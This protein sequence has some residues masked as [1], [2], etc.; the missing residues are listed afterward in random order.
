M[1]LLLLFLYTLVSQSHT[2]YFADICNDSSGHQCCAQTGM[3][4]GDPD[5]PNKYWFMENT[6]GTWEDMDLLCNM[7]KGRLVVIESRREN[8]CLVKYAMDEYK[9]DPVKYYA[10][11]LRTPENY[12]GVYEW[13]HVDNQPPN[14]DAA[15]PSFTNWKPNYFPTGKHCVT[16]SIGSTAPING[17]WTD[18]DCTNTQVHG[19]CEKVEDA[20]ASS[21]TKAAT[22]T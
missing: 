19:I 17:L 9:G 12:N 11:G 3:N 16:L 7:E 13:K 20:K 8:D 18:V 15:T 5:K 6:G 10:I 2:Q 14:D 1:S 22:T 4:N 21:A